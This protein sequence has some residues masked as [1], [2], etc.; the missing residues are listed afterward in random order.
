MDVKITIE[1][2]KNITVLGIVGSPRRAGNTEILVDNVLLGAVKGGVKTEKI[3]LSNLDINP[4]QACGGCHKTSRCIQNDDFEDVKAKLENSNVW[5]LGTPIYWWGPT[6]QFKAFIDR[7][8]SLNR[9]IFINK[10]AILIIACGG[11]G[12]SYAPHTIAMLKD[13]MAY[14]G[15][16]LID[17]ILASGVSRKGEVLEKP[18]VLKEA[19]EVGVKCNQC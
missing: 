19:Y 8:Y 9:S 17:I 4:C 2:L 18:H 10:Y 1:N 3:I 6:A 16:R 7:W 13:I 14:L 15:I 5:V 11:G 12:T